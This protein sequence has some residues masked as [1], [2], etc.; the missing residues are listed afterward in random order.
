M[1]TPIL[2]AEEGSAEAVYTNEH[3]RTRCIA[4]RTFGIMTGVFLAI[5]RARKLYYQPRKVSKI[6]MACAVLHNFRRVNG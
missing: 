3:A 5:K 6:I 2:N 1:L 4:E